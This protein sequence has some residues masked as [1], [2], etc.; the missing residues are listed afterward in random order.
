M[1]LACSALLVRRRASAR[2]LL[3]LLGE[4]NGQPDDHHF[5]DDTLYEPEACIM[6]NLLGQIMAN[7]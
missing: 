2:I 6:D 7:S 3:R 5:V 1:V 4:A